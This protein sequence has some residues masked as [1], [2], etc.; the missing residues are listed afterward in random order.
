[1]LKRNLFILLTLGVGITLDIVPMPHFFEVMRP[2]WTLMVVLFW[3]LHLP[4]KF[5]VGSAW[6]AGMLLDIS[7]SF[8]WGM[9]G[10]IFS[11]LCY[12]IKR[13]YQWI[14]EL[15]LPEQTILV[16]AI[17]IIQSL[18]ITWINGI[19]GNAIPSIILWIMPILVS[20]LVWPLIYALLTEACHFLHITE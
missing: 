7:K 2:N 17:F 16:P 15:T 3:S 1:M 20:S 19:L 6:F 11:I 12:L 4:T 13:H 10:F 18:I 8:I 9:H 14:R 5:G